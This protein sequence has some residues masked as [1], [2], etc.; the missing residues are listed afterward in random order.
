MILAFDSNRNCNLVHHLIRNG[1]DRGF[2]TSNSLFGT[3]KS[4]DSGSTV[5]FRPFVNINLRISL[6]L[7]FVNG[8]SAPAK[9]AGNRTSRNREF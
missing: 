4:D 5:V 2:G 7:D 3:T 8:C 9:D 6:V 1:N